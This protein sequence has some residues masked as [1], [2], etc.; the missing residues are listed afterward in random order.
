MKKIPRLI[1]I[2][3]SLLSI[4]CTCSKN[5]IDREPDFEDIKNEQAIIL[6][7]DKV[8]QVMADGI[9]QKNAEKIFSIFRENG[10]NFYVRDGHIYPKVIIA[11]KQYNHFFTSPADSIPRKFHFTEKNFDI[12]SNQYVIFT[13]SGIIENDVKHGDTQANTIAYTILFTKDCDKWKVI[14]MHISWKDI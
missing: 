14:N 9:V 3:V 11:E 12:L 10:K 4:L 2:P 8:L 6:E 5:K 7:V 13:G 1:I